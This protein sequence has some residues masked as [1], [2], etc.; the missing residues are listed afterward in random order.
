MNRLPTSDKLSPS[1]YMLEYGIA[2]DTPGIVRATR[3]IAVSN[4]KII[5]FMKIPL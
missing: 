3:K 4:F 5:F 1:T 2:K